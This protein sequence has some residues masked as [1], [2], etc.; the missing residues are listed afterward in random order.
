M[1][2]EIISSTKAICTWTGAPYIGEVTSDQTTYVST[3]AVLCNQITQQALVQVVSYS[4]SVRARS[5]HSHQD[6]MCCSKHK[7]RKS[8]VNA[9]GRLLLADSGSV[10]TGILF[11]FVGCKQNTLPTYYKLP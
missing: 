8:G 10:G 5:Q 6:R 1:N 11:M 7:S 2:V 4:S 3:S 9:N